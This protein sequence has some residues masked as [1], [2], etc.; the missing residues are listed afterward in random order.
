MAGAAIIDP[1]SSLHLALEHT[2]YSLTRLR[3]HSL[4]VAFAAEFA[5]F[6][7]EWMKV[8]TQEILIEIEI[9][10]AAALVIA[11]DDDLDTLVDAV[12]NAL[13]I[14]T[15]NK[16][17]VGLYQAYFR[18]KTPSELK[19]PVLSWQLEFMREWIGELQKSPH[20]SLN[21]LGAELERKVAAAYD[22]KSGLST[23]Q[24]KNRVFRTIGAR[25]ELFDKLNALRKR[26]YGKVAELPHTHPE[27]NLPGSFASGFFKRVS[28]PK[29][30]ETTPT[31]EDL[32]TRITETEAMLAA[33]RAQLTE[34]L[35]QEAAQAKAAE[36][37]KAADEELARMEE[38]RDLLAAKIAEQK[39]R[40]AKRG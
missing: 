28:R 7:S 4:T 23:A 5:D 12:S 35:E 40:R 15:D 33:L 8:N 36:D 13:K 10:S 17:D 34:V 22:A 6:Q 20:A 26:T 19:R 25:K 2:T 14:L 21:A 1:E 39:A 3:A 32:K 30:I 11:C 18:G 29:V 38:E 9:L 24:Q 16:A 37:D 27:A 31:S